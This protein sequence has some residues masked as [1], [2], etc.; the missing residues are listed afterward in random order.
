MIKI[1]KL[2]SGLRELIQKQNIGLKQTNILM[3]IIDMT[4][5]IDT[6]IKIDNLKLIQTNYNNRHFL[7]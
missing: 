7:N 5:D 1:P 3:M 6:L 2:L 4:I